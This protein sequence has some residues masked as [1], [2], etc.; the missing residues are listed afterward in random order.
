MDRPTWVCSLGHTHYKG[1]CPPA[2]EEVWKPG[3]TEEERW[4]AIAKRANV[5]VDTVRPEPVK[6]PAALDL[7]A[8]L[9]QKK[10]R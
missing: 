7:A 5:S 3:A 4:A 9:K 1:R 10:R 8:K 2:K 6:V